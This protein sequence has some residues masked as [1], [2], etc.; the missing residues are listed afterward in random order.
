[1]TRPTIRARLALRSTRLAGASLVLVGLLL[2]GVQGCNYVAAAAFVV[3]G[4]PKVDAKF[5]LDK[6]RK[7]VVF[8][9]DRTNVVPRRSLRQVMGESAESELIS[10][11]G[12]KADMVIP[13]QSTLRATSSERLGTPMSVV[14]IGRLVGADVIIYAVVTRFALTPDGVTYSPIG[15]A[16]VKVFDAANNQRLFPPSGEGYLVTMLLPMKS[17]G[18]PATAGERNAAEEQAAR[19]LGVQIARTF[20]SYERD[21]LSG[22]LDD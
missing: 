19:A 14:D 3:G 9:D 2:A 11:T 17:D 22:D 5:T 7:T 16:R 18:V 1:M 21:A 12:L 6:T 10:R 20:F 13:S 8:I 15:E 4:P